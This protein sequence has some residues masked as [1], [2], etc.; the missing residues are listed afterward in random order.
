MQIVTDPEVPGGGTG[1]S[2]VGSYCWER[3][4]HYIYEERAHARTTIS[5]QD[6]RSPGAARTRCDFSETAPLADPGYGPEDDPELRGA[7]FQAWERVRG[8]GAGIRVGLLSTQP[9]AVELVPRVRGDGRRRTPRRDERLGRMPAEARA[10]YE[11]IQR[12]REEI[13]PVDF[14]VVEQLRELRN[15][16]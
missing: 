6:T 9:I 3:I 1:A 16:D 10:V 13:G 5:L 2:Q 4:A 11:R 8:V 7:R 14:D 15:G 12:L